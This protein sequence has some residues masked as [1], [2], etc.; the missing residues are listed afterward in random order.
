M[1][2]GKLR[3]QHRQLACGN[4]FERADGERVGGNARRLAHGD[5]RLLTDEHQ[6][7]GK[8]QECAAGLGEGDA[9]AGAMK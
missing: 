5:P 8:G 3:Q 7:L 2:C 4:G 1:G 9:G 6:P